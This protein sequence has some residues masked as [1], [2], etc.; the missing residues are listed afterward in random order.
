MTWPTASRSSLPRAAAVG[1]AGLGALA[2]I[3]GLA[4]WPALAPATRPGQQAA[5]SVVLVV[6][7]TVNMTASRRMWH[8]R[9]SAILVSAI[10]TG[11]FVVYSASVIHDMG[12]FFWLHAV[13]LVALLAVRRGGAA[14]M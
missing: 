12:E 8:R 6:V 1:A 2:L 5:T 13:Y 7:G 9:G 3:G 4:L 14:T 10:V 11:A